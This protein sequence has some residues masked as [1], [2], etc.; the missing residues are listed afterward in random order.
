MNNNFKDECFAAGW[1]I[2]WA[3]AI[4]FSMTIRKILDAGIK[5][6]T[7]VL[8]RNIIGLTFLMPFIFH[9]LNLSGFKANFFLHS[10]RI[11]FTF[12]AMTCTYYAYGKLPLAFATALGFSGPLFTSVL[13]V[14]ILKSQVSLQ[15]W[16]SIVTGYI[17]ILVMVVGSSSSGVLVN[18]N[19]PV[20]VMMFA[21]IFAALAIITSK[22]LS[23][24]EEKPNMLFFGMLGVSMLSLVSSSHSWQTPSK[25]D[26]LILCSIA[27]L[28]TISQ[29][30]Y[31][32]ALKCAHPPFLAPFEYTRM[33]FSIPMGIFIL[34][35]KFNIWSMIGA[36]IIILSN[37]FVTTRKTIKDNSQEPKS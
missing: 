1:M 17:G 34:K 25:F 19:F 29:Y 9:N 7:I 20:L 16:M 15:R 14:I 22:K 37:Y 13:S 4:S 35:E 28:A 6:E 2:L 8:V 11:I 18:I 5:S 31:L 24:V 12:C 33:V 3:I 30:A 21:N 10:K 36:A 32:S 27:I 23:H 26:L